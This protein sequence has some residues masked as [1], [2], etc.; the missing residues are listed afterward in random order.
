LRSPRPVERSNNAIHSRA[1][2]T[3][4]AAISGHDAKAGYFAYQYQQMSR[5]EF[6]SSFTY[7]RMKFES[8]LDSILLHLPEESAVLDIG[9]GTGR[10]L[11]KCRELNLSIVGIEPAESMRRIARELNPGISILPATITNLPFKSSSFDAVLAVEVLRYL[12]RSDIL[13]AYQE[14]ARVLKP[15]GKLV[16]TMVNRFALN[17]FFVYHHVRGLVSSWLGEGKRLHCEFVTPGEVIADFARVGAIDVALYGRVCVPVELAYKL[18]PRWGPRLTRFLEP[19]DDRLS[20]Q[21]WMTPLAGQLVVIGT[22]VT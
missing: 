19:L 1:E 16:F 10:Y 13:R 4:R 8:L 18:S 7:S 9:C 20:R 6:F 14:M 3:R 11:R 22:R 15:R 2:Q 12:H 17:A 5:D 21:A